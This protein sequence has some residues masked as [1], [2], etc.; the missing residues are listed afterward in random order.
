M[1]T[2][3]EPAQA[4]RIGSAV[5]ARRRALGLTLKE[6]GSRA[7]TDFGQLSRFERGQFKR[8]SQNLQKVCTS[9]QILI[10]LEA[11]GLI[12]E[13]Q[14]SIDVAQLA[15]RVTVLATKSVLHGFLIRRIVDVLEAM[16]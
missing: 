3:F 9:L 2:R 15:S 10:E 8:N 5:R 13:D 6:C 14:S 11:V 1:T 16:G 7:G 4:V 12:D